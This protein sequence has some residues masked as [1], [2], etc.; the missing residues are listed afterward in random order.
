MMIPWPNSK[1]FLKSET[2]DILTLYVYKIKQRQFSTNYVKRQLVGV[3]ICLVSTG[4]QHRFD[5]GISS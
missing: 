3:F 4:H 1:G 2:I 5:N